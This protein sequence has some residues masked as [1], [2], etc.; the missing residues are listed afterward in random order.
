MSK[1]RSTQRPTM[2]SGPTPSERRW[3]ASWL[4]RS[5]SVR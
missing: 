3:W 4:A 1:E 5:S 2:V